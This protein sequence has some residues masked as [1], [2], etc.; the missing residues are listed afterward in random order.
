MEERWSF[1]TICNRLS[2]MRKDGIVA[3][4][5][6]RWILTARGQGLVNAA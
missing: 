6:M 2:A 3:K 1:H 5:G 4:Q